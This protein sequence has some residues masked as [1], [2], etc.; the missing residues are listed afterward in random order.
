LAGKD[1]SNVGWQLDLVITLTKAVGAG[2][3]AAANY[4]EALA[5]LQRLDA[6]GKLPSDKKPW[7]S[8][9]ATLLANVKKGS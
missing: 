4:S 5:V 3:D 6:A 9:V 7:L 1:Q 2:D 8:A